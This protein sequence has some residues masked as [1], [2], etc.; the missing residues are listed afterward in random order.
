[1]RTMNLCSAPFASRTAHNAVAVALGVNAPPAEI[2]A[3]PLGWNGIPSLPREAPDFLETIPGILCL[4]QPLD[5]LRRRFFLR[6]S[7][8]RHSWFAVI[9]VW[10]TKKPTA[11]VRLAVG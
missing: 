8:C 6:C 5:A 9:A 2:R 7:R 1:M 11:R 10:K 4:L 3:I